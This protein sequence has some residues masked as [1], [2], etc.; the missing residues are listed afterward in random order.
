MC[1][2]FRTDRQ[3]RE[4]WELSFVRLIARVAAFQKLRRLDG[5]N[6][7]SGTAQQNERLRG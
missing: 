6:P 7:H 4:R 2:K 5:F 1:A 3:E